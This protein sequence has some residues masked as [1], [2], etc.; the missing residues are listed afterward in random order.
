MSTF[1]VGKCSILYKQFRAQVHPQ[2]ASIC[3]ARHAHVELPDDIGAW[4]LQVGRYGSHYFASVFTLQVLLL[5]PFLED[6]E[7][8]VASTHD[9]NIAVQLAGSSVWN[10]W[11][12]NRTASS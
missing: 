2:L 11:Q 5:D 7:G 6:V 12:M 8:G 4:R 1:P 3:L 10:L 9:Q